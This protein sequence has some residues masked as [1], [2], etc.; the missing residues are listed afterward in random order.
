LVNIDILKK[1]GGMAVI[2]ASVIP[3]KDYENQIKLI[4]K[5]LDDFHFIPEFRMDLWTNNQK[6]SIEKYMKIVDDYSLP[7]IFTFRTEELS[8]ADEIYKIPLNH[9]NSILDIDI[10]IISRNSINYT[11]NRTILSSHFS[12]PLEFRNRFE[13][14]AKYGKVAIKL[15]STFDS[16]NILD[17][18]WYVKHTDGERI[19]SIVPQGNENQSLRIVSALTVSDFIYSSFDKPVIAGQYSMEL[20][21]KILEMIY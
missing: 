8:I 19:L 11:Q 13:K 14:L 12:N 10:S 5:K 7:N 9:E 17:I 20:L 16:E 15:A 2:V 4:S 18:L 3:E 21:F 1:R 6:D